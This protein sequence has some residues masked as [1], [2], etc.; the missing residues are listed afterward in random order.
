MG[1]SLTPK[2]RMGDDERVCGSRRETHRWFT[3]LLQPPFAPTNTTGG[4]TLARRCVGDVEV[5]AQSL[6]KAV[7]EIKRG[8][9]G[10]HGPPKN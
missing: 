7:F 6:G 5:T 8:K 4:N 2:L 1:T 10:F 9:G 3:A